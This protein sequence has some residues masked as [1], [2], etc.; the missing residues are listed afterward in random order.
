MG[1]G[2]NNVTLEDSWGFGGGRYT[3]L[4]YGG[5][6][7]SP[8]NL[9]CDGNT[10][11]RLVLRMGPAKSS[12]G[13]P[14]ASLALYYASNNLVEDVIAVDGLA[15]SDTSNSAFYIT[16]HASRPRRAAT[17][18]SNV[19]AVNNKGA[20]FWLDCSGAVCNGPSSRTRSSGARARGRDGRGRLL[21]RGRDRPGDGGRHRG[22]GY[23]NYG[24][25]GA[26]LTNS[27]FVEER[28]LRREA[29]AYEGS[30]TAKPQRLL[31]QRRGAR[32]NLPAGAGDVTTDP[33]AF[34]RTA[35]PWPGIG[36][37]IDLAWLA[38]HEARRRAE[39]CAAS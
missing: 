32:S 3:V 20:G 19:V 4:C 33:G 38:T 14:Q 31:R 28:R 1:D 15:A 22:H 34:T 12:G 13:N 37:T 30:T 36:A 8:K 39:M 9:T 5:P 27:A 6:G 7:G 21:H 29:G 17:A 25:A 2:T 23:E 16:G 18:S 10:F 24:C 11:R 26:S 35:A